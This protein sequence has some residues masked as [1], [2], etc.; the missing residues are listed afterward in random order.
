MNRVRF[1]LLPDYLEE[2]WP[3]MD[4]CETM[5]QRWLPTIKDWEV[6]NLRPRFVPMAQRLPV[7][8]KASWARN[9][10]RLY[11][12]RTNYQRSMATHSRR[13]DLFHVVDHSYAHL[14]HDLPASRTGVYCHDLDAF[15]CLVSPELEPRSWWFRR[16]AQSI[17]DGL[18]K[19]SIVFYSTEAVCQRILELDLIPVEKLLYAPYGVDEAFI[20]A[21]E[22]DPW[23]VELEKLRGRPW[24]MHVGGTIPRKRIDIL[25]AVVA[26]VRESNPD[27]CL[28][29]VG[30]P[31]TDEQ[32]T[33]IEKLRLS[34]AIVHLG[35]VS[36]ELLVKA[37]Q[38]TSMVLVTSDAEGFGLPLIE[39]MACGAPVV[40]SDIPVLRESGGSGAIFAPV[41]NI[42]AWA[43]AI[44][45]VLRQDPALPNREACIAW[46]SKFSWPA[47]VQTIVDAYQKLLL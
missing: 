5:L 29:K 15:R 2:G 24:A 35:K 12:R 25:L 7:L 30:S 40:A 44:D 33:Q 6:L 38:R 46:A 9:F 18:K 47:H 42:E 43:E 10:D 26:K 41:S 19:A 45:R 23:P 37:Y 32:Q 31:W 36:T 14:I 17:L 21:R 22:D 8:G 11:N 3:S 1:A 13:I 4:L 28:C 39:A 34:E 27:F 20:P 16:M